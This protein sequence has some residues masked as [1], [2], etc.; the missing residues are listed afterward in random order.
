MA[1]KL[2]YPYQQWKSNQAEES[3][4]EE[5]QRPVDKE[6]DLTREH[7]KQKK[8]DQEKIQELEKLV[9]SYK[10]QIESFQEA[11]KEIEALKEENAA[12]RKELEKN[13]NALH[14]GFN[15]KKM[16]SEK[17]DILKS[18]LQNVLDGTWFVK[19]QLY[20]YSVFFIKVNTINFGTNHLIFL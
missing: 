8:S 18:S 13:E 7:E 6:L 2:K 19:P 15:E 16:L 17:Y 11:S 4:K 10:H 3:R 5:V 14:E 12:L 9:D 1:K 20:I